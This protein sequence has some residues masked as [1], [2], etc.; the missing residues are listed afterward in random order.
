MAKALHGLSFQ[1]SVEDIDHLLT[2][3]AD[4]QWSS[5]WVPHSVREDAAA[6]HSRAALQQGGA[7]SSFRHGALG[8][9]AGAAAG[10][11]APIEMEMGPPG[12]PAAPSYGA[13]HLPAHGEGSLPA[14][15][16]RIERVALTIGVVCTMVFVVS[17]SGQSVMGSSSASST[18]A[19]RG[20]HKQAKLGAGCDAF[21]CP[22]SGHCAVSASKCPEGNPFLKANSLY[23]ALIDCK[24]TEHLCN[25]AAGAATTTVFFTDKK[26]ATALA[27]EGSINGKFKK[28]DGFLCPRTGS[29]HIAPANCTE[30]DPFDKHTSLYWKDAL[31]AK[32]RLHASPIASAGAKELQ[33]DALSPST[34][35]IQ[36]AH[37][38]TNSLGA[39]AV[40][41]SLHRAVKAAPKGASYNGGNAVVKGLVK[42]HSSKSTEAAIVAAS[43]LPKKLSAKQLEQQ[44]VKS[45]AASLEK[46]DAA[47][48]ASIFDHSGSVSLRDAAQAG[49]HSS[50]DKMLTAATKTATAN[51]VADGAANVATAKNVVD[52][53]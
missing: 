2:S 11:E 40:H 3:D 1:I 26:V 45:E 20:Q 32:A 38:A 27:A 33:S 34:G 8:V 30:G 23:R 17:L 35:K 44:E 46:S 4:I 24:N 43:A 31:A 47:I 39:R 25:H 16:K 53:E 49:D 5:L 36:G 10:G 13:V 19:G 52:K 6:A 18:L 28:C 15:Y 37:G 14:K 22:T 9:A 7:L 50:A 29:C 41:R 42:R 51:L 12:E 48:A 21:L